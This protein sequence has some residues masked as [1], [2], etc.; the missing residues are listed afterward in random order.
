MSL[1]SRT[2]TRDLCLFT[3]KNKAY[4]GPYHSLL[5]YA[6]KILEDSIVQT[7]RA[8]KTRLFHSKMANV[9]TWPL[10]DPVTKFAEQYGHPPPWAS[11]NPRFDHDILKNIL[12]LK[13]GV[14]PLDKTQ[15]TTAAEE[16]QYDDISAYQRTR[17]N[18]KLPSI[19]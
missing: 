12:P 14:T 2:K 6:K 8:S 4:A 13:S 11:Q 18:C 17:F 5:P 3:S 16:K 9:P 15:F 7:Y 19:S 10:P 1:E